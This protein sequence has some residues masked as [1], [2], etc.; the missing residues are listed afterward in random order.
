MLVLEGKCIISCKLHS[1]D[2]KLT[3][4]RHHKSVD[5]SVVVLDILPDGAVKYFVLRRALHTP[6]I[7]PFFVLWHIPYTIF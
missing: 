7:F 3:E 1:V 6:L 5:N 2:R 4:W